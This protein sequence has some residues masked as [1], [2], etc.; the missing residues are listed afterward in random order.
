VRDLDTLLL[1]RRIDRLLAQWDGTATPGCT[2]GVVREGALVLHRSA[3]MASLDLG[4]PIG[5]A[6]T[7]RI[8]SVSKQFTCTAI[9]LLAAEGRLSLDAD[10]RE[11]LPELPDF[12]ARITPD[13][14]MHNTSGIRDFLD[15]MRLGGL[16]LAQSCTREDLIAVIGRQRSLNFAPGSR[17][18]YSNTGFLLLGEIAGR[19]A[20]E[21]LASF[22]ERR[23][24]APLGMNRT[25][26]V[27]STTE[28]VAGLATGYLPD[29]NGGVVKARHG[30]PL[31][32]EG[33][34]VS[35]VEDL[36]LWDRNFTTG[37]VGGAGIA[38]A[39]T[40]RMAFTGGAP[41]PYARGLAVTDHRGIETV[42]HGGLWPGYRTEF[43]RLPARNLSVICIVNHGGIDPA[44]LARQVADAAI[45]L[46]EAP[47]LPETAVMDAIEG[48]WV[49]PEAPMTVEM[50]RDA[51]GRAM[52]TLNGV[53]FALL[54]LPDGSLRAASTSF[55]F[56]A[57]TEGGRLAVTLDAGHPVR[58]HRPASGAAL[59]EGLAGRYVCEEVG[60]E[61]TLAPQPDGAMAA[62]VSGPL[63]KA[64][65]WAV[66]PIE[67]DVIRIEVPGTLFPAWTDVRALREA[68]GITALLVNAGR[69]RG[70]RFRR[71]G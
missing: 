3:G 49:E 64:G 51:E 63:A 42:S 13:H 9:L 50:S 10:I 54:P 11:I 57:R 4:V 67:G 36:A 29:G 28:T 47:M 19:V 62:S 40:E 48:R 22:L 37:R 18:L 59:P 43:L 52:A 71:Q 1:H 60:A 12:G 41:N 6:T 58:L 15:L 23:V 21:P 65:P 25:H 56:T 20:G 45:G 8:A 2:V 39:L 66:L 55:P 38:A 44:R 34:L 16:D 26:L 68:G 46:D 17:F 27:A 32:G 53:G 14:L 31:G 70:L 7:F 69:S 61:W 30:F 33:G 5:A 35:C 24:F